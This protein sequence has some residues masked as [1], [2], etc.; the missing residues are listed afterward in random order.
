MIFATHVAI[1]ETN[2]VDQVAKIARLR[3]NVVYG[4]W[5]QRD[6]FGTFQWFLTGESSRFCSSI[7]FS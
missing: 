6:V 4:E 1:F 7:N 5:R 2:F 3:V